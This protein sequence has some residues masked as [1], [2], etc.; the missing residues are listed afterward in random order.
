MREADLEADEALVALWDA[1]FDA[2]VDPDHLIPARSV[3][4]ARRA[5]GLATPNEQLTVAYWLTVSCLSLD[6]LRERMAGHGIVLVSGARRIPRN[7]LRQFRREFASQAQRP[8]YTRA[9]EI[10]VSCDPFVWVVV[11]SPHPVR[12]YISTDEVLNIHDAL[13]ADFA[14]SIDPIVPPGV[15]DVGLV[16]SA[17]NRPRTSMGDE[18]K[19][20]NSQM[21][22]AALFHSLIQNHAFYNG[23]KRTA[24]VTMLAFLDENGLVLTASEDA[25][26]KFTLR[27][28]SH[29]IVPAG[30]ADL[31]DR[32]TH[33]I[34]QWICSNTR[35][36]ESG[37]RAMKWVRLRQLLR[38]EFGCEFQPAAGVGNRLNVYRTKPRSKVLGLTR[39]PVALT[40]Q[41]A[42]SGD[43]S[44]ADKG[45]IHKIR[46]DLHLD[47]EHDI[48][49]ATFYQGAVVDGF[50]IEYRRILKRLA[51]L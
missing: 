6:D 47:N 40:T 11:G 3:D 26:L 15:K 14:D 25:L 33:S 48:D 41:V 10:A 22:A 20:P 23:N 34:A 31:A 19:Y 42:W 13:E 4:A 18:L 9:Q 49:S 24:I 50:I 39:R 28:A 30:S 12:R 36:L 45:T 16:E 7:S 46:K 21:A 8:Q 27:V 51:R 38:D 5:L 2:I 37:E 35:P 32:E 43:G 44:D 29:A 17:V 1:G